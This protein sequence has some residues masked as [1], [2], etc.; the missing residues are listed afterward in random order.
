M[1]THAARRPAGAKITRVTTAV[2]KVSTMQG[3]LIKP[4]AVSP[5]CCAPSYRLV[6]RFEP[7]GPE[8]VITLLVEVAKQLG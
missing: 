6:V 3:T 4:N 7:Q 1:A 5:R 2:A 8:Q